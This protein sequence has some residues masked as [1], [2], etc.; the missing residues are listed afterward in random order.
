MDTS[1]STR[2]KV[3]VNYIST[4]HEYL[5]TRTLMKVVQQLKW[6]IQEAAW[7]SLGSVNHHSLYM[8]FPVGY[9]TQ[10]VCSRGGERSTNETL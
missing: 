9:G 4:T 10:S 1:A 2:E 6:L 8:H 3:V 5:K 7:T